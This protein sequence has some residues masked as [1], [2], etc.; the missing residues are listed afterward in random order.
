MMKFW[1][2]LR[3]DVYRYRSDTSLKAFLSAWWHEPGFRFTWYLRKVSFYRTRKNSPLLFAYLY[4][5]I[6]LNHYRFRY[7]FDISPT[8][9]IG[10]G[11]FLGHFGGVVV[12]PDAV[13]GMNVNIN[14][15]ATIGATSRGENRGAPVLED[16]VWIGA[17]SFVV[18]K[19]RVQQDAMIVPGAYVN[20]DVDEKS[21]ILGNPGQ[22]VSK[23][24]S[25]GYV[26]NILPGN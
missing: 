9:L 7:G 16:R 11:L 15:G 10:P 8:T 25:E 24:G 2:T 1:Q 12:S 3:A 20:F 17:G 26:N 5:R 18:G 21:I 13:I 6:M 4:N 14:Q 23:R 19:I 22:C